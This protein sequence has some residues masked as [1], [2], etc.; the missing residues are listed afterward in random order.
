MDNTSS[1]ALH[2]QDSIYN[3]LNTEFTVKYGVVK[4]LES[5]G[6]PKIDKGLG[7]IK[8]YIKGPISQGGD[9]DKPDFSLNNNEINEL[10]WCFPMLPKH[11]YIQPKIGEVVLIFTFSRQQQHADRLYLGPIISQLPLLEKDPFEF[12]A[13]AGF[14]FGPQAPSINP[15]Q[16]PELNGVFPKSDEISFQGRYNTD[17]THKRNEIV[18]RAGKFETSKSTDINPYTFKFNT[19]TQSYIQLKNDISINNNKDKGGV[20]NLVSNKINLIT[21]KDGNPRFNLTN[22]DNLISDDELAKILSEA[23][24]LPFGDIL[25]E[26]LILLKNAFLNHVHNGNGN[27]PTDLTISGNKQSVN[28]FKSKAEDLEK[29]MLSQNIRIN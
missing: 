21:H 2:G 14:T 16:I 20:I 9:G 10:P 4:A 23:H 11:L 7:R 18:I 19:S 24:Q 3:N 6:G 27:V 15:S 17:I 8:V 5:D 25:L 29:V 1:K 22:Q 12:S 26:Y 13:L 28:L